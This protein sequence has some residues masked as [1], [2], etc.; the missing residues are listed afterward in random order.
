[1]VSKGGMANVVWFKDVS[2]QDTALV[3]TKGVNIS[4]MSN[5]GIP[6]PQGFIITSDAFQ[7]FLQ[8]TSLSD[9]IY[10]MLQNLNC[11]DKSVLHS[12][13]KSVCDFILNSRIPDN[14]S[15]EILESYDSLNVDEDLFRK[16]GKE[17]MSII[18]VGREPPFVAVRSSMMSDGL[19]DNILSQHAT[20]LNVKGNRNLLDAVQ[21]CWASL[22]T[23]KSIYSRAKSNIPHEDAFIAIVVQKMARSDKSGVAFSTNPAND[24]NNE[25]L[26]E[27]GWGLGEPIVSR[28]ISPDQYVINK[29]SM[30]V[31]SKKVSPQD[32]MYTLDASMGYT[33]RRNVFQ[34]KVNAQKL[35]EWEIKK[36][37][38]MALRVEDYYGQPQDV[39]Y[40]IEGT[41]LYVIRST[42]ANFSKKVVKE[43]PRQEPVKED[44]LKEPADP[45]QVALE[46]VTE[47]KVVIGLPDHVEKAAATGADGVGLL[48][49]NL[50]L[51][52]HGEHPSYMIRQGRKEQLIQSIAEDVSRISEAF[53][54]K[55]V[56]YRTF[57]ALT[58]ECKD[59][60]GGEEEPTES[61]PLIGWR[62]I[63]R[64]LDEPEL[65][66]AEFEAIK[67]VHDQGYTNVGVMIPLVINVDEI[68]AAKD[69]LKEFN[70]EPM[71]NIEFG[72]VIETPAAVQMIKE[73]CEEGVDFISL[74]T[75]DLTQLTLAIDRDNSRVQ[76]LYNEKHP[77][78]LRQIKHVIDVCREH[79]VET[80][81]C[82]EA[83]SDP[84][85]AEL[86][87]KM[88]IDSITANAESVKKI[89]YSVAKAEKKLLLDVARKKE[90]LIV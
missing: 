42:P 63:R 38:D 61:N 71:E 9:K 5:A 3:G 27:A 86:L 47:V 8:S 82:G 57:D 55:P 88:G 58:D 33:I 32:W 79:N 45:E 40:A 76:K 90:K 56:W 17:A 89:K 64:S 49:N 62:S 74:G 39:E 34:E 41:S 25:M 81:I 75:S 18:K 44:V 15:E 37:A 31:K 80:S 28:N 13:S 59:V 51:T 29:Q 68:R 30:E 36:I 24:D 67:R 12:V 4:E 6:V 16:L 60:R 11:E 43:E 65:L 73:I 87:V 50:I 26:I 77:A 48:K 69:M 35:N 1:M 83:G 84:E 72:A 78:V 46:T 23:P 21:K 19:P 54:G 52:K 53:R 22:F 7:R 2:K 20:F 85:M 14:I 10:P 66:R 70:L